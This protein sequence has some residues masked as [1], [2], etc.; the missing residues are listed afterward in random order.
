MFCAIAKNSI[1]TG[2][3]TSPFCTLAAHRYFLSLYFSFVILTGFGDNIF[4]DKNAVESFFVIGY[5]LIC[6][7]LNAYILGEHIVYWYMSVTPGLMCSQKTISGSIYVMF[8]III[9]PGF[10]QSINLANVEGAKFK[11]TPLEEHYLVLGVGSVQDS[12]DHK[13]ATAWYP[14]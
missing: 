8:G 1:I 13:R 12:G 11:D 5:L 14:G 10:Q 6:V 9:E 3:K 7:L 2:K 4:Y